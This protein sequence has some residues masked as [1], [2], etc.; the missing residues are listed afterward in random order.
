MGKA[1]KKSHSVFTGDQ[2]FGRKKKN[3]GL[4]GLGKAGAVGGMGRLQY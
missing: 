1:I 4:K 3:N 2:C